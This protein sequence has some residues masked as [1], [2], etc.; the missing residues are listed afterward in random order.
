VEV[1]D[2]DGDVDVDLAGLRF[3]FGIRLSS[4]FLSLLLFISSAY[5]DT[6][7]DTFEL[8]VLVA[9]AVAVAKS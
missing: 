7:V 8:E 1:V 2:D 5:T 4:W 9:V 3:G 6:Y